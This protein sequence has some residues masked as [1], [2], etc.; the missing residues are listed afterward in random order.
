M[1]RILLKPMEAAE[2][3]GIGRT[4]IYELLARKALPSVH[5]GHAVRVP[6]DELKEWVKAHQHEIVS[7]NTQDAGWAVLDMVD[8]AL[9]RI[10]KF[11]SM[12]PNAPFVNSDQSFLVEIWVENI[13]GDETWGDTIHIDPGSWTDFPLK[14]PVGFIAGRP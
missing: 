6:V 3:L 2:L 13:G 10:L 11:E 4:K 7:D 8:P 12:A 14:T 1:E 9:L 5:I